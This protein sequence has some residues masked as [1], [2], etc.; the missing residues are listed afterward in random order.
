MEFEEACSEV[1]YI[2]ENLNPEDRK[3]IS[4]NVLE[5]FKENKSMFY[6]VN[7]DV[8]KP[9]EE[10]ELKDETKAFLQMLNYKYFSNEEQKREFKKMLEEKEEK[11]VQ[12]EEPKEDEGLARENLQLTVYKENKIV[13]WLKKLVES[14]KRKGL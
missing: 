9:L 14:L 6:K 5:F 12:Q 1:N 13:S 11:F 10:Q 2:L 4:N 3:K 7:L 8:S